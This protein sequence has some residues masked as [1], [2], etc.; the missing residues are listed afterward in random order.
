MDGCVSAC[1]IATNTKKIINGRLSDKDWIIRRI[2]GE[3]S[4]A[5]G[6]GNGTQCDPNKGGSKH[7]IVNTNDNGSLLV[8]ACPKGWQGNT[9]NIKT[10]ALPADTWCHLTVVMEGKKLSLYK[11]GVEV[12]TITADYSVAEMGDIAFAYIGN[13]IYAHNGDKD[14]KGNIKDFR[15]YGCAVAPEQAAAIYNDKDAADTSSY[16]EHL[17][18]HYPLTADGRDMSGNQYDAA[19][20]GVSFSAENGAAF[21]GGTA[22]SSYL[23][24]PTEIFDRILGND[25]M[26]ISFWVKDDQGTHHYAFGF[27]NGTECN[28]D[29]G[30]AKHFI[31]N[32]N[33]GGNLLVNACPKGWQGN[34][35]KITTAAPAGGSEPGYCQ[36]GGRQP[37][38]GYY[39]WFAHA[40]GYGVRRRGRD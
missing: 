17:L 14:F 4:N 39:G 23:S 32:T 34:T 12:K 35:N 5:F 33:D 22:K 3:K 26:T 36:R 29:N 7:F 20:T 18:A 30:G 8:N 21:T 19:A 6:F 2:R 16:S 10:T 40:S 38:H 28:P 1:R 24:L 27:G 37:F 11:N 31:V 13:A 25:R 9:N 15:V